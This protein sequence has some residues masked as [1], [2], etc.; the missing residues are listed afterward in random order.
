MIY[1]KIFV[2]VMS[3]LVF[4]SPIFCD[5]ITATDLNVS[6]KAHKHEKI[7]IKLVLVGR[8]NSRMKKIAEILKKDLEF[9]GQFDVVFEHKRGTVD[10]K[11]DIQSFFLP[12]CPLGIFLTEEKRNKSIGW[13]LYD[14]QYA[15]MIKGAQC[16]I[17]GKDFCGWAHKISD[18]IWP[19]LANE[20]GFFST[21][22][23]YCKEIRRSGKKS[24]KYIYISDYDGSNEQLLVS[25]PTI[26]MVP[27]WNNDPEIPLIFYSEHTNENVRLMFVDMKGRRKIVSNFD[28]LNILSAFSSDGKKFAYCASRGDGYCQIYYYADRILKRITNKGNNISPT[29]ADN[30]KII[31]FC[32]DAETGSPQIY[33]YE[34]A[35]ENIE[36]ISKGGF[37]VSTSFNERKNLLAYSK[38]VSRLMQIFVYDPKTGLHRQLTVGPGNK[39]ECSWSPCGNYLLFSVESKSGSG[40]AIFNLL[41]GEQ[42]TIQNMAQNCYYPCWSPFYKEFPCVRESKLS[43]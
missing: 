37:T 43:S 12:D 41:T 24:Y 7:K 28:G 40:M 36:R 29:F 18:S 3:F 11:A 2:L 34:V 42:K 16:K 21:K 15:Y 27:R 22:I 20:P 9:S 1:K 8:S 32:S 19:N 17:N 39:E 10:R 23:T 25:K 26:N 4:S 5:D 38:M 31:Y 14:L 33:K 13:R 35:S 6:V 30:G